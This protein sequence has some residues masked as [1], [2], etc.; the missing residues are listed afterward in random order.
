M[1]DAYAYVALIASLPSS[2]RLFF[3]KQA[4]LSRIRLERRL[5]VLTEADAETLAL[6]ESVV[7]WNAYAMDATDSDVLDR[8]DHVM[9]HVR[10]PTL[11]AIIAERMELRT[12]VAALRRRARGE[13]PPTGRWGHGRWPR[14]IAANWGEPTF[15]LERHF[16][17][18]AEA[19][20]M[21]EADDPKGLERFMLDVTFRQLQRH[22]DHHL[23]DF[24]AVVIYVLKWNIFDRWAH[25]SGETAR[26]RFAAMTEAALA[27]FPELAPA[28]GA[29]LQ[30]AA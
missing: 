2:E 22:A 17:W 26:H 11:R 1:A 21:I 30:G 4:P 16:K 12:L 6:I 28:T 9:A 25:G 27:D 13:G 3:A 29:P 14:H 19:A 20:A 18:L 23:F 5:K 8:V 10:Q 24:E 7:R 15:R